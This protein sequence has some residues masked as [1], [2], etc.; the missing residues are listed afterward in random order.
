M[1]IAILSSLPYLDKLKYK[2][3]FLKEIINL[4][5]IDDIII[6][7]SNSSIFSHLKAIKNYYKGLILSPS[8]INN[9][10]SELKNEINLYDLAKQ[11]GI[12][13]Y[14]FDNFYNDRCVKLLNDYSPDLIH[15]F[16]IDYIPS[17]LVNT[18]RNRILGCHY[19][20][21]PEIRG[22]DT[23]RWSILLDYPIY[24]TIF[25]L[26]KR[27][28]M[29]P[30]LFTKKVE[31]KKGDTIFDIRKKCQEKSKEGHIQALKLYF[32]NEINFKEQKLNDGRT[33]YRMGKH[34]TKMVDNI[35]IEGRYSHY[36]D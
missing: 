27:L 6:V 2:T 32:Q 1:K 22:S 12:K 3:D 16:S 13:V 17:N 20:K 28:D 19:A 31:V 26:E 24:I 30:I 15:N 11:N 23:I 8:K 34:L 10:F 9:N 36:E 33:Y 29:G 25:F 35:L 5:Y 18:W 4:R 14:L 21:L 7:Y